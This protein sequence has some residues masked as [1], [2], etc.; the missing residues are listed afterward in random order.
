MPKLILGYHGTNQHLAAKD[1][2]MGRTARQI[3]ILNY[4]AEKA[5]LGVERMQELFL[6]NVQDLYEV[7]Q[8]NVSH[9]IHF[10]RIP[11]SLAP[12]ITNPI[13]LKKRDR[14]DYT[15]MGYSM[16]PARP[17]FRS[18]GDLARQ[19][20]L[21]LTFHPGQ[22]VSLSS[23]NA[24]IVIRSYRELYY[25]Y[26]MIQM[27]GLDS[28]SVC[29]IHGGGV[30]DD[31]PAAMRRW[32]KNFRAM[33][34]GMRNHV[35]LENDEKSYS[36]ADVLWI[37]E[38]CGVPV[39]FDIFHYQ[40]YDMRHPQDSMPDLHEIFQRVVRSWGSRKVKMHISNQ[41]KSAPVGTHADYVQSIPEALLNFPK[42]YGVDLYLMIEAKKNELA[43]LKLKKKYNL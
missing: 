2:L 30:Y 14:D 1:K 19:H 11:S 25:H 42:K 3:T 16:E 18:I 15:A 29:V 7:I 34:V 36:A 35:A 5:G 12:H 17:L 31:K 13:L 33:P 21:R 23:A 4:N 43:M 28:N 32:V 6:R 8:W 22:Y 26:L 37:S 10:Y 41:R 20:N 38:H 24:G 27:M 40:I 9:D 39:V